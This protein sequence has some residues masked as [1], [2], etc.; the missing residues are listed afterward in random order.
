[1][2]CYRIEYDGHCRKKVFIALVNNEGPDQPAL[3]HRLTRAFVALFIFFKRIVKED[4]FALI[5]GHFLP[6][7]RINIY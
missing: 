6:D 4:R 7:H 5:L 2:V 3:L 1:M